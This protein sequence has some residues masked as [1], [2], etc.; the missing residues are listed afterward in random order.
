S[1][2][3][4]ADQRAVSIRDVNNFTRDFNL[5][6]ME[7]SSKTG[8]GVMNCFYILTFLMLGVG[9]PEQLLANQILFSP[10][11]IKL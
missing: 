9:A 6:Y 7:T 10:G 3:D 1:K 5:F 2:S 4:L 8:D 11:Q